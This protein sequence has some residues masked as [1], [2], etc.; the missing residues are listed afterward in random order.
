MKTMKIHILLTLMAL[1][2]SPLASSAHNHR[3]HCNVSQTNVSKED[4]EKWFKEVREKKHMFLAKELNL[5]AEQQKEFFENYD[6]MEDETRK[7][8]RETRQLERRTYEQGDK[9]TDLEYQK[10]TEAL[11]EEKVKEAQIE[12]K[13]REKFQ[14]ILS[15]EQLFKLKGAER[16]FTRQLMEQHRKLKK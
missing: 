13:Y 10:A 15:P 3:D 12:A 2:M 16:K 14:T 11:Y 8:Q 4:R 1:A 9:T 5:S 7:L 6:R